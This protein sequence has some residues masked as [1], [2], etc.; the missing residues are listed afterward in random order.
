MGSFLGRVRPGSFKVA[1]CFKKG[2]LTI[3]IGFWGVGGV[4]YYNYIYIYILEYIP[5]PYSNY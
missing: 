2:A 1:S 5:K 3:R 4:P